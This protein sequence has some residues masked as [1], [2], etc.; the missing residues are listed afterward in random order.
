MDSR[1]LK[2]VQ[3]SNCERLAGGILSF[4]KGWLI[5]AFIVA[6]VIGGLVLLKPWWA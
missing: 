2:T 5:I 3:D 1:Q 4:I 6:G